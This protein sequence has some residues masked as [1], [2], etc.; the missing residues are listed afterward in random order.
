M[1]GKGS[2]APIL[3]QDGEKSNNWQNCT[4]TEN[5]RRNASTH[6]HTTEREKYRNVNSIIRVTISTLMLINKFHEK[7]T[8]SVRERE[9]ARAWGKRNERKMEFQA[10]H[11][12]HLTRS[13]LHQSI[14]LDIIVLSFAFIH[15]ILSFSA[16]AGAVA[17][18]LSPSSTLCA[19]THQLF[20]LF[21]RSAARNFAH[22]SMYVRTFI[23][24]GTIF[25]T[26]Q[27]P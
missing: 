1:C 19:Q 24:D 4:R 27:I 11:S 3:D 25:N 8:Q 6:T 2:N 22:H 16:G 17:L 13:Q 12:S 9:W 5:K 18:P 20:S 23:C 15:C 14:I 7:R 21:G 26:R 10:F